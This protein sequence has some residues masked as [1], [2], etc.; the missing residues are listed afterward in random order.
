MSNSVEIQ[1][2]SHH[3]VLAL[4]GFKGSGEA[5]SRADSDAW[6]QWL[7]GVFM[8]DADHHFEDI[9]RAVKLVSPDS[10]PVSSAE[11]FPLL[12]DALANSKLSA[13]LLPQSN[14]PKAPLAASDSAAADDARANS[15]NSSSAS[16]NASSGAAE[17]GATSDS[18]GPDA[19]D[20]QTLGDPVA[21]ATGEELLQL[22]DFAVQ[23]PMPLTF[24]RW[25]RSSLCDRDFG[26]GHGWYND[27]LRPLWQDDN[28]SYSLDSEGR[29]LRFPLLAPK[30]VGWQAATG[31]RL[32]HKADGRMQLSEPSGLVWVFL[33][34][35][36]GQWRVSS[37]HNRF[38]HRWLFHYN[39]HQQLAF[40]D[41]AEHRRLVLNWHGAH[42]ASIG[43]KEG[44]RVASLG[45]YQH[46]EQGDL[47]TVQ[48][49]KLR[50]HYQ[51]QGHLLRE[52][53]LASGYRF[54]LTWQGA[55][56]AAR[57]IHTRGEDGSDDF[58]FDYDTLNRETKVTDAFGH[59]WLYRYN[60]SGQIT[61]RVGPNGGE[62]QWTYDTQ[63]RLR[64]YRLPDG[65][66]WRY[67]FD[68]KGMPVCD[69]L[70]DGRR[71]R[72]VYNKLGFCI[73]ET[74]PDG[75]FIERKLDGLGRL[76]AER[77]ADGSQWQYHY[78][79]AG[80]LREAA[81]DDGKTERYG[82][83]GN[84]QPLAVEKG[85]N[86]RRLAFD[87]QGRPAGQLVH[88]L[89]TQYQYDGDKLT[90]SHQYPENAPDQQLSWRFAY[91][92][93]GRLNRYES[94]LGA[95]HQFEYDGR[96]RP[97]R[98]IRPD[99]KTVHYSY[100]KARRLVDLVRPDGGRWQLGYDALGQVN[101]VA[102]PDGRDIQFGYDA[103]GQIIHRQQGGDW[104]QHLKRDAGGRVTRQ[105][106]QGKGRQPVAKQFRYDHLGRMVT[107][108]C[109]GRRL[110]WRYDNQGRIVR[111]DQDGH[112][113][114][115]QYGQAQQLKTLRLPDGTRVQFH[116]GQNGLWEQI[117]VGGAVVLSR[118]FDD[119]G[120]EQNR[121]GAA[122]QQSQVFDRHDRL[123]NRR[124]Q[125][126]QSHLRR[127]NWDAESRLEELEDSDA[128]ET[129]FE[130]DSV[131]QLIRDG[132][133]AFR[134]D[135]GGNRRSEG[136][137]LGK[138]RL[139]QT[140][141][142]RRRYDAL[143]AEV[144]LRGE[145]DESR[146][147]DAEGGLIA[148][149][150]EGLQLRY[151]YDA[152]NRR[153]WRK[154]PTGTVNYLWHGDNLLG[155]ER[156]GRWQWFIRDPQTHEP[157]LTIH[158]DEVYFY[159]LDWRKAPIRLW[160]GQGQCAW[161]AQSDAWGNYQCEGDIH[162][163]LRLPGQFEDELTGLYFN[164]FR[165]YDPKTGRYLTPDPL[166]LKGGLNSYRYTANP[167]DYIDPL[168]LSTADVG[169]TATDADKGE[170]AAI[171]EDVP[172]MQELEPQYLYRGIHSG[173][174]A[175]QDALN[176]V[177]APANQDADLTP[178]QHAEGGL[179]GGSQYVSWTR[180]RELALTHAKKN[181]SNDGNPGLLLSVPVGAPSEGDEWAWGWTHR[182][183]WGEVEM[184]QIGT[185]KNV[186]VKKVE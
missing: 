78:D 97:L 80:W 33:P 21:P 164:R 81:S 148:F 102:A 153:A 180:D 36:A 25:Y 133:I 123:I 6:Q 40:V 141:T 76:L 149:N 1:A 132:D 10:E 176:G 112:S 185:R 8:V 65:R 113:V 103:N 154:G 136:D 129:R 134:Y 85:G 60:N 92:S 58:H 104:L 138:D 89:V 179:T 39:Q 145:R 73:A 23:G 119:S 14:P 61:A 83:D 13:W 150:R 137:K 5:V 51:Y 162:Q 7:Q 67:E 124:W 169:V 115:Y 4:P 46:D 128:G 121:Q 107:A 147:F 12:A 41:V 98:Y 106:S 56:P 71:H 151:G 87:N 35:S 120:R 66:A 68:G 38:G 166:G 18:V 155:E 167:V 101:R 27:L 19:S 17:K 183:E 37:I 122:N 91:D 163:P 74:L 90:A 31:H 168:G 54:L 30:E 175:Y 34:Q 111:H 88:D 181:A 79:A 146:H 20:S 171:T 28:H 100:D 110:A 108:A 170:T 77:R 59:Q 160:S 127:Y 75:R 63:G 45:R 131:G 159:E 142:A 93:A 105:N 52:R 24:K 72:R 117:S 3:L 135:E 64:R 184:L 144:E 118:S 84:G 26:L 47:I 186:L 94:A 29:V 62:H 42:L 15:G 116:Y 69:W 178:E 82:L 177:V 43:L 99:G 49:Q 139:L 130:R 86:L 172:A 2:H 50:E 70:P 126:Q 158:N 16:S 53:Q 55:G 109:E 174:P 182:N 157:L 114:G 22:V 44:K 96:E 11:A 32:E 140:R 48:C 143:G 57:C 161:K 165:D 152:L 156:Q 95:V 125:G 173:H 9:S